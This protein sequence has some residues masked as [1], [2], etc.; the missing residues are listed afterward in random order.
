MTTH[1]PAEVEALCRNWRNDPCW[2]LEQTEGFEEHAPELL[3]YRLMWEEKWAGIAAARLTSKAEALG[4]PG[5]LKLA[6]HIEALE[7]Q[8]ATLRDAIENGY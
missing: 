7:Q 3:E 4:I 8:I 5:N 6:A 2:N 1:T